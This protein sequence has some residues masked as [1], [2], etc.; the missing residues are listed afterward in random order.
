MDKQR[1]R[2]EKW[3]RTLSMIQ[4]TGLLEGFTWSWNLGSRF[5]SAYD[6]AYGDT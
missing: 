4:L 1:N 2:R 6:C 3:H 5:Q